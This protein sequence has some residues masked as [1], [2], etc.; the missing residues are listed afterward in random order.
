MPFKVVISDPEAGGSY[1]VEVKEPEARRLIGLKIGDKFDG[2]IAGLPG[3]EL[4][5][6]GGSDRDGFPMRKDISGTGRTSIVLASGP[7]FRPRKKGE[8]RRKRV[9]GA[10]I[11]DA[12]VQINAKV[13][14]KGEKLLDQIFPPK[15][16]KKAS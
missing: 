16:E 11:S 14:K 8:R 5:I 2:V 6:T 9:R 7:G 4:L 3:Y 1:Q 15:E 12:I 10:Q 13:V